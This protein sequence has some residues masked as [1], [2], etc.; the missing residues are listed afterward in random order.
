MYLNVASILKNFEDIEL[1]V[2]KFKPTMLICSE[3]CLTDDIIDSEIFLTGYNL[4]RCNSFSR[5]TGGVIFYIRSNIKAEII[6]NRSYSKNL[7]CLSIY[8]KNRELHGIYTAIYHSPNSSHA[9]FMTYFEDVLEHIYDSSKLNVLVGDFNIDMSK[10]YTYSDKLN[11]IIRFHGMKQLINVPTRI[12][13]YSETII[14]LV[15]SNDNSITCKICDGWKISDHESILIEIKSS[16]KLDNVLLRQI[17][18]WDQYNSQGLMNIL[19][20]LDWGIWYNMNIDAKTAF[21]RN[22]IIHAVSD[23][24]ANK[25]VII[26]LKNKWYDNELTNMNKRKFDLYILAK[27][28]RNYTE[29]RLT[30]NE[31]KRLIKFK[32]REYIRNMIND[33]KHDQLKMWKSLKKL[34]G[35]NSCTQVMNEIEINGV[36]FDNDKSIANNLNEFY[37]ESVNEIR[38]TIIVPNTMMD[39]SDIIPEMDNIFK[40]NQVTLDELKQILMSFNNKFN[41]ND[42]LN[43]RVLKDIFDAI[44]YFYLDIINTSLNSGVFPNE[45]K[46]STIVPLPKVTNVRKAED[47]RPINKLPIDE[48]LIECCVKS[49]LLKY[50]EDANI[51]ISTQSGFRQSHSCETALN[52]VL[53][54]WKDEIQNNKYVYAVFLD[55]KRAFETIDRDILIK[56]LN[57][58]GIRNT[59]NKW[60][61]DYLMNRKQRTCFN[62]SSSD[63]LLNPYGVPQGSVLGP[64]LFILYINDINKVLKY[65]K[66]Y[67]FADDALIMIAEKN[68]TEALCKLNHDLANIYSWLCANKLKLNVNKTKWMKI[69][70]KDQLSQQVVLIDNSVIE[71]VTTFKYLGVLIDDRL[72]FSP[73][74][75]Y[76]VKKVA[77]KIGYMSRTCYGMDRWTKTIIYQT[78]VAPYFEYCSSILFLCNQG[79]MNKLQIL[80]NRAMRFILGRDRYT[81]K[82]EMLSDLQWLSVKQKTALNT[83]ILIFKMKTGCLP[84]YLSSNM[85]IVAQTH[86]HETRSRN[87]YKL[88]NYTKATTQNDLFYKGLKLFNSLPL[89]VKNANSMKDFRNR[90]GSYVALKFD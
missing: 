85:K 30:R 27:R 57:K 88:P 7:W 41:K 66:I 47:L 76:T 9:D 72:S 33:A 24:V 60:F 18:S 73:H 64:L 35:N 43:V 5:H 22:R 75:E 52:L 63:E 16:D 82:N 42:L 69:G 15:I 87:N 3:T 45:L 20:G 51:L 31:Y 25:S 44:G 74:I 90:C 68:S 54:S 70:K 21:L 79:D 28:T 80:Q 6:F 49:Q 84:D 36:K 37:I 12:T 2:E 13:E 53:T 8:V 83:L 58:Y 67:L 38:Q 89:E 11:Q 59:E 4:F 86:G 46:T 77:K 10:I 39:P 14:D 78:I 65:C 55:F 81:S 61:G 26:K 50:I 48:K 40:F 56:K 29:Y 19:S 17:T 32:K 71:Q 1:H 62:G 23:C 34:I